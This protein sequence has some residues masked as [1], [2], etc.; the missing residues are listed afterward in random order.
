MSSTNKKNHHL[1]VH[2]K[3]EVL[4]LAEKLGNI[5]KACNEYKVDRASFYEW[6]KRYQT[7]NNSGLMRKP[8]S[9]SNHPFKIKDD[10]AEQVLD[11]SLIH[12][13]WGCSRIAPALENA[14]IVITSPTVQR[15]LQD[16]KLGTVSQ[17]LFR[18]EKKYITEGLEITPEQIELIK[19]N[20]PC[21]K[22]L[23][24]IGTYPGEILVQ[25]SFPIFKLMSHS[26]V[27]LVLDTYSCYAFIYFRTNKS[28]SSAVEL[29]KFKVLQFFEKNNCVVK[30][31]VTG[32]GYQFTRE[33]SQY[34]KFLNSQGIIH[35]VTSD[36]HSNW[37]G[38]IERYKCAFLKHYSAR[39]D[40]KL[41]RPLWTNLP[42]Y[43]FHDKTTITGYPNFGV[44]ASILVN[45]TCIDAE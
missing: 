20:N 23:N 5:S 2:Q 33:A 24:K 19:K 18:L 10:I 39:K 25:D 38:M 43:N 28:A 16:A 41:L 22:E 14:G 12:P 40:S 8:K 37:N 1:S 3:L 45:K 11:F 13:E 29:M 36:N 44:K 32:R 34:T 9:G 26:Y 27:H 6:Q 42:I 4:A 7:N 15:I 17:R 30:K 31:V 35:E 21:V